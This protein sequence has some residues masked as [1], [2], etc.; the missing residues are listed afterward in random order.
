L[1]HK[2]DNFDDAFRDF[3][4]RFA[5]IKERLEWSITNAQ[6]AYTEANDP[7]DKTS[8]GKATYAI[9]CIVTAMRYMGDYLEVYSNQ[10]HFYESIYWANKDTEATDVTW[11][12][13]CE[14]W[15]KND[16][17]GRAPTIAVIDRMRQILWDEPF[18]I[19]W[20]ARPEQEIP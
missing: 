13:I 8:F 11:K 15:I 1:A 17:E 18:S 20:A 7:V 6:S 16:F 4:D 5:T 12:A 14:A 9:E 19:Q 10:S 2:Y 3:E